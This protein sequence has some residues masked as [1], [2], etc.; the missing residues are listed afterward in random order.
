MVDRAASPRVPTTARPGAAAA[1]L[2]AVFLVLG[3]VLAAPVGA[4]AAL[5]SMT[6]EADAMLDAA[7]G[8]VVL[9]FN[10]SVSAT[11][12]AVRVFDPSG[13]E[14]RGI[15]VAGTDATV[16]A[17]LP[18]FDDDGS[19]TVDWKVVSADGHPI[20]GAYLFHLRTAT[21]TEPFDAGA[22][23]SPLVA[24][25]M[26]AVGATLALMALVGV[27]VAA[28]R[29]RSGD[30]P[31]SGWYRWRWVLVFDGALLL[32]VGALAVVGSSMSEALEVTLDTSSGKVALLAC[33]LALIGVVV[34]LVPKA[35]PL[36]IPLGVL[37]V[38]VI[39]MQGHAVS[40]PPVA[41]SAPLTVVHVVAA[42][43]WGVG[44]VWVDRRCA[45]AH[46]AEVRRDVERLSP[47]A[48]GAVVLLAL[49]G[50]VLIID[51]VPLD[52]LLSSNYG[53]LGLLKAA[54]LVVT[55]VVAFRNRSTVTPALPDELGAGGGGLDGGGG[56]GD[57]GDGEATVETLRRGVRIEIVLL[58]VA[59]IA[60]AVLS[61]ISPPDPDATAGGLYTERAAFGD[62][63]VELTV[64]PG[65]RGTNEVHVIALGKDGRLMPD[66]TE[67]SLSLTLRSEDVGPLQPE[68]Q[69]VTAGH[70]LSYADFPLVGDWT[71]EVS[72]RLGKFE[73]LTATFEVPIG[74]R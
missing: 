23:G 45:G 7:P 38:G 12:D 13:R 19:Y 59:L 60:G 46:A 17:T 67:L 22:S 2:V 26:R 29:R 6:P 52:Q 14:L 64:E 31:R 58:S 32:F 25:V 56:G 62:G 47:F 10:E 43:V 34:S 50:V 69:V 49:T 61:Q 40:L 4:H 70:S 55:V 35:A 20:R 73:A 66:L 74:R 72:A 63:Q 41:L 28:L 18:D 57:G 9:D 42:V 68:M 27:L 53:R 54:L 33:V 48:M 8:E 51:R 21:L 11:S 16:T 15:E 44:L 65:S 36:E 3:V 39:A 30:T 71:V 24:N 37:T 1:W 5:V